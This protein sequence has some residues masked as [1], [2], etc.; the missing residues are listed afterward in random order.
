M[1]RVV[2]R[3]GSVLGAAGRARP[4]PA[5]RAACATSAGYRVVSR[6]LFVAPARRSG[7]VRAA[8]APGR[9]RRSRYVQYAQAAEQRAT[10]R[11]RASASSSRSACSAARRWP[12]SPA[13]AVARR[14]MRPIAGLTR[15]AR[16]VARTRDPDSVSLPK[17][18][19]R[20]RGGRAGRTRSRTMLGELGAARAETEAALDPPAR[21]SWPTPRTSCARRS[22]AS[23]PTSS[24]S[25]RSCEGDQ[26]EIAA[27]AL[28]SSRRMR[29]L[30]ADLLL[31][32]R[33]DAGRRGAARAGGPRRGRARGRRPR[34]R[35]WPATHQL[36][37][38]AARAG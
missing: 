24:C 37:L 9:R 35:R 23:S 28:R 2:D 11:S 18:A 12:S 15:A 25:R 10:A 17:P 27:S 20:R 21:R 29:R 30:V 5:D 33:A 26:R 14:A 13:C 4:R 31:L 7:A 8:P 3:D 34:P 6:P 22:P 38:D 36:A 16:E 1:I 32:A 19:A